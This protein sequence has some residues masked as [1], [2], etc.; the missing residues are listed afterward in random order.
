[1]AQHTPPGQGSEAPVGTSAEVTGGGRLPRGSL[2]PDDIVEAAY[3]VANEVARYL[4]LAAHYVGEDQMETAFDLQILQKI[5][6]KLAGN[7]AR[8]YQPMRELLLWCIESDAAVA[9]VPGTAVAPLPASVAGISAENARY[10]RSAT[11][12]KRML[13]TLETVG[14]VSFVE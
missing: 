2:D 1:M 14:F 7:R 5:L 11:K 12:L 4:Q 8:L 9:A 13:E 6:P 3:R 10:R